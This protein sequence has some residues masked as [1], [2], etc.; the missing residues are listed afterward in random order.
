MPSRPVLIGRT[1]ATQTPNTTHKQQRVAGNHTTHTRVNH[2][3]T[4]QPPPPTP[5]YNTGN[6]QGDCR[7]FIE[8][9]RP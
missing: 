7:W 9:R 4:I 1:L 2:A 5:G 6:H 8:L 3:S